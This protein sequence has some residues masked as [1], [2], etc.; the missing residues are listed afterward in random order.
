[1]TASSRTKTCFFIAPIGDSGSE[2][3]RHS[4]FLFDG[5]VREV[6]EKDDLAYKTW[7]ADKDAHPGMITDKIINDIVDSTIVVADLTLLNPNVFYEIGIRHSVEK[8]IIHMIELGTRLP[9]DNL[10]HR[11]IHFDKSDWNSIVRTRSELRAQILETEKDEFKVTNPVTNALTTK[12]F[13][14]SADPLEQQVSEL[15]RRI[16]EIES[17]NRTTLNEPLLQQALDLR[18]LA[19]SR[20]REVSEIAKAI[21]STAEQEQF[22]LEIDD[23]AFEYSDNRKYEKLK[24]WLANGDLTSIR[25][26]IMD[27]IPF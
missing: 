8:P 18:A 15:S 14:A 20:R 19:E 4:D 25:T 1:M 21:L 9:F 26:Q 13:K 27:R 5:I 16:S 22:H 11:A 2:T 6:T 17:K 3:R 7:R 23:F 12:V 10:G 24:G